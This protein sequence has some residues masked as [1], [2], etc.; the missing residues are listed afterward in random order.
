MRKKCVTKAYFSSVTFPP[1]S[2]FPDAEDLP[3]KD[4]SLGKYFYFFIFIIFWMQGINL[5]ICPS[6]VCYILDLSSSLSLSWRSSNITLEK[7]LAASKVRG[8]YANIFPIPLV[9]RYFSY[10]SSLVFV[11]LP[12]EKCLPE[13][14]CFPL[15][16][17]FCLYFVLFSFSIS[18]HIFSTVKKNSAFKQVSLIF[19]CQEIK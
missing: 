7:R 6:F 3:C 1:S 10:S 14:Q 2:L 8:F 16:I 17:N 18:F 19:Q 12:H 13:N 15:L 11:S 4:F 9:L 5:L